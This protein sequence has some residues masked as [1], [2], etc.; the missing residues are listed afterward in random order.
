MDLAAGHDYPY[1]NPQPP[2]RR[3]SSPEWPPDLPDEDA[4]S[5]DPSL[6]E[7]TKATAAAALLA[8][9]SQQSGETASGGYLLPQLPVGTPRPYPV[10]L[11]PATPKVAPARN[12][13]QTPTSID[14]DDVAGAGGSSTGNKKLRVAKATKITWTPTT[15][16]AL[17]D[18]LVDCVH[19]GLRANGTFHPNAWKRAVEAV[20]KA[21]NVPSQA[22]VVDRARCQQKLANWKALFKAWKYMEAGTSGWGIN[23]DGLP[24][25][26]EEVMATYQIEHPYAKV[27]ITS[28]LPHKNKLTFLLQE[29]SATGN[30]A[31]SGRQRPPPTEQ[32]L[33]SSDDLLGMSGLNTSTESLVNRTSDG[34]CVVSSKKQKLGGLSR[35]Q[36]SNQRDLDL[37]MSAFDRATASRQSSVGSSQTQGKTDPIAAAAEALWKFTDRFPADALVEAVKLMESS[38]AVARVFITASETVQEAL[39]RRYMKDVGVDEAIW[40]V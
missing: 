24:F 31:V 32:G 27:L 1:G 29:T 7:A 8:T 15:E 5:L 30:Y 37:M 23:D 4:S 6:E 9:Y 19:D 26:D 11:R 3:P 10:G 40:Q 39:I 34:D 28:G 22:K 25:N 36:A 21:C 16:Q 2:Y 38:K 14:D 12:Q 17:L 35:K 18:E 33:P 13:S 20:Q